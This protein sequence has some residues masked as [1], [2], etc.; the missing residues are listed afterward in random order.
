MCYEDVSEFVWQTGT[1]MEKLWSPKWVKGL[2]TTIYALS[3]LKDNHT[4]MNKNAP[5]NQICN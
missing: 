2:E 1:V 3:L 4:Q 5:G